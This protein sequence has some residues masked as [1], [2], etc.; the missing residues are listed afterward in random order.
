MPLAVVTVTSTPP[1]APTGLSTTTCVALLLWIVAA[2]P[3]NF[4]AVAPARLLPV[5]VTV[6]PPAVEPVAGLTVATTG[7]DG[8]AVYS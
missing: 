1:T 3:P 6:V 8:V 7:A 2:T 4:T 5:I